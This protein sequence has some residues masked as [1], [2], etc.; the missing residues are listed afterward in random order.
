MAHFYA[1]IKGRRGEASRL[2]S[3]ASGLETRAPSWQGA[4]TVW[5][6]DYDGV[7]MAEVCLDT[8]HG[9][10]VKRVLYNGPVAG[11]PNGGG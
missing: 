1:C 11:L 8:H 3:K 9:A 2:G 7:D 6:Y 5:L 4:V 10:G